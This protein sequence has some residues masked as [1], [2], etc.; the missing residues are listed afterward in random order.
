[1]A[2]NLLAAYLTSGPTHGHNGHLNAN[3]SLLYPLLKFF[4]QSRPGA[5]EGVRLH[6]VHDSPSTIVPNVLAALQRSIRRAGTLSLHP[7]LP[8]TTAREVV[9]PGNDARWQHYVDLLAS[10]EVGADDCL[11]AIDLSDVRVLNPLGELCNATREPHALFTGMDVPNTAPIKKWLRGYAERSSYAAA[12]RGPLASW[13]HSSS[14]HPR[15]TVRNVGIVGGRGRVGSLTLGPTP[16][17]REA[18]HCPTLPGCARS[19]RGSCSS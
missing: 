14:G 2:I 5:L 7:V 15:A 3:V 1:M 16:S 17:R 19:E 6:V 11:F 4:R 12:R 10:G 13:L 8:L 18:P 9:L